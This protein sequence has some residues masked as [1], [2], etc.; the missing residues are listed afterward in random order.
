MPPRI[1]I[2]EAAGAVAD[3]RVVKAGEKIFRVVSSEGD[4]EYKVYVDPERMEACSTD[5]GTLYRNY[6][7]YPI[8]SVLYLT[9][10]IPYDHTIGK[11][12]SG[13]NWRRLNETLKNYTLV[14]A[15]VKEIAR[16]KGVPPEHVDKYVSEVYAALK[17]LRF[18]KTDN[19][20]H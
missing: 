11:A 18:S 7:G 3:N 2:L 17:K 6:V 10:I 15:K 8:I 9:N 20:L 1:K 12:L 5:N 13:I 19:C 16:D 4:R 14:E